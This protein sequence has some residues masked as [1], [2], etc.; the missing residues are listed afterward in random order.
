[1]WVKWKL[2]RIRRARVATKKTLSLQ[3]KAIYIRSFK[4]A[5]HVEVN[6]VRVYLH[7]FHLYFSEEN[8]LI[9][10]MSKM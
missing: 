4:L 8:F 2:R 1:M 5:P 6:V 10:S 7:Q 9:G 3:L